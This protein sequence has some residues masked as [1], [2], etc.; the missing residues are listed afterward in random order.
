MITRRQAMAQTCCAL[1]G[2]ALPRWD[3][4]QNGPSAHSVP[5]SEP[6]SSPD[7]QIQSSVLRIEFDHDLRSRVVALLG[8]NPRI[9]APFSASETVTG[10]RVWSDFALSASRRER[11]SDAFG[12]GERLS[13][14]GKSGDL[15]KDVSVTIYSEFPSFAIFDV[16]YTN[17]GRCSTRDPWLGQPSIFAKRCAR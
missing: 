2:L 12:A 8:A 14:T 11:V 7:L 6:N 10:I 5:A 17:E 1:L 3:A 4:G 13:L 9:L 15:R 16:T